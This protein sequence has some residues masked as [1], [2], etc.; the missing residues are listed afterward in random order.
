MREVIITKAPQTKNMCRLMVQ[1][2]YDGNIPTGLL[3]PKWEQ[4]LRDRVS[5][6]DIW[7]LDISAAPSNPNSSYDGW[8]LICFIETAEDKVCLDLFHSH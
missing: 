1:D 5:D 4:L 3:L 2:I 7:S 6:G 8:V